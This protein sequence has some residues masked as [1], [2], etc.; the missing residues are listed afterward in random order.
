[1]KQRRRVLLIALALP[2]ALAVGFAAFL[3]WRPIPPVTVTVRNSSEKPI[4]AVRLEHKRGVEVFE[5][6]APAESRTI[7]FAAGGETSY[8][9]RV[10]FRD[11]SEVSSKP[12]YEESGY[13]FTDTVSDSGIESDVRL[14]S[15]Y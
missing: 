3:A 12:Q 8:T 5:N 2:A 11:G 1:M 9:L 6:L 10:R 14:P 7:R 15:L 13:N 4:A